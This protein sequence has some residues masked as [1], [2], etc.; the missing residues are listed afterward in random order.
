MPGQLTADAPTSLHYTTVG[1]SATAVGQHVYSRTVRHCSRTV[2]HYS[3]TVRH[4]SRTVRH[5][6]WTT[7]LHMRVCVDTTAGQK[8]ICGYCGAEINVW[9]VTAYRKDMLSD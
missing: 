4:Y 8:A 5:C 3:R 6:S 2:R 1:Q 9:V 7:R